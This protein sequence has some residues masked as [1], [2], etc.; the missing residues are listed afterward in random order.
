MTGEIVT[1]L[2]P[3]IGRH[4]SMKNKYDDGYD[5]CKLQEVWKGDD[6]KIHAKAINQENNKIFDF[7]FET[8]QHMIN[9]LKF[10]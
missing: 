9:A 7:K 5:S 3:Y 2:T 1:E 10:I 4:F 6:G 8:L